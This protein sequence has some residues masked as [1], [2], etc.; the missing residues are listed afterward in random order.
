M[1]KQ[2]LF[3]IATMTLAS[4]S[5]DGLVNNSSSGG[6]EAPIAFSVEKKNI[7]RGTSTTN[8]TTLEST[9]HYNF[10]VW[11]YKYK[12]EKADAANQLVMENYLVGYSDGTSKGYDNSKVKESTWAASTSSLTDHKSPWFYEGLGKSEYSYTGEA[13]FY[14]ASESVRDNQYL[15]Y[16]DLAYNNTKFYAYTPYKASGVK[17]EENKKKLTVDDGILSAGYSAPVNEFLYAGAVHTNKEMEDVV[18]GFY[19]LGAQVKLR[20]YEDIP[21]YNV[22]IID[23]KGK[24]DSGNAT[25]IQATPATYSTTENTYVTA[26]YYTVCGAEIDYS[27]IGTPTATATYDETAHPKSDANLKFDIPTVTIPEAGSTDTNGKQKYAES[28]TTYYPVPQPTKSTTGFTFHVSYTLT[29][30]DNCETITVHDARV[31]VPAKDDSGNFVAAWQPNTIYYYTF[32]ITKNTNGTTSDT[33]DPKL[34]DPTIPSDPALYPIV[35]D[36]ATIE[37][38]KTANSEQDY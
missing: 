21:G 31:F 28:G 38:Y 22:T 14:K 9:G 29:A 1:K 26:K 34:D 36:G 27:T 35:F 37:E 32:R 16:W 6:G 25:G 18:L 10:G 5:S 23:V 13:G 17:F 4:C 33:T 2:V 19:H 3:A 20:F 12:T 15:R 8:P 24:D 11:A 7:T 30:K